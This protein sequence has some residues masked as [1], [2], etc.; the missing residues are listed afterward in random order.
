[1]ADETLSQTGSPSP[2]L[3][4]ATP[5]PLPPVLA[6]VAEVFAPL[7][8]RVV[9]LWRLR[10]G[11]F[12]AVVGGGLL[13]PLFIV[14]FTTGHWWWPW[15]GWLAVVGLLLWR[16][17]WHPPRKYQ[18]W[19]YRLDDKVLEIKEGIWF[20]SLTLLPLSRLQHVDLTAGPL[21]RGLGLAS[22]L[23]HTAGTHNALL[24]LPGLEAGVAKELRDRLV[25]IGGDDGV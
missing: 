24:V 9:K 2:V 17:W 20:R 4:K 23:F 21:E 25:T 15:L 19:G 6:G 11:I 12:A 18:S 3:E 14:G 10:Q 7:D 8:P 16:L 5:A 13:F 1:M 22:L